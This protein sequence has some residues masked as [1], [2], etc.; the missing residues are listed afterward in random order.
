M[1]ISCSNPRTES[2]GQVETALAVDSGNEQMIKLRIDLMQV[3][4]ACS[5][6]VRNF[7]KSNR[8]TA[9]DRAD[10][11]AARGCDRSTRGRGNVI[12]IGHCMSVCLSWVR[13][14]HTPDD[15]DVTYEIGDI[16]NA[17]Y[18]TSESWEA[19]EVLLLLLH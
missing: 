14:L 9:G 1:H 5:H 19:A 4:P 10:L 16:V 15:G 18:Q 8:C 17:W 11:G 13:C 6:P 12:P 7:R 2:T 3:H